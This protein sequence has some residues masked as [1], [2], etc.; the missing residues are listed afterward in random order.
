MPPAVIITPAELIRTVECEDGYHLQFRV[1]PAKGLPVATLVLVHGMMSHS[2]WFREL[3]GMLAAMRINVVGA[4]RRGSG[5]NQRDRGDAPSREILLSDLLRII[6]HEESGVPVYLVGWCWG[7]VLAVNAALEFGGR[8]KGL[9]LLA[10]GLFPSAQIKRSMQDNIEALQHAASPPRL[11]PSPMKE[12]MFSDIPEF[13]E[14]IAQDVLAVRDFTP[15]F[16]E[17]SRQMQLFAAARLAQLAHPVLLLLA[18]RD[19]AVDNKTTLARFR[20]LRIA[21][22]SSATLSC[23]HAMQFEA[24]QEIANNIKNWLGRQGVLGPVHRNVV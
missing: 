4:E 19:Q 7:A 9:V 22:V 18:A 15:Q 13:R 6:D 23:N 17:V 16:V 11:L 20:K 10:P 1:W 2:G 12:E 8:F 24:P 21:A 3:A 5:L 14:L